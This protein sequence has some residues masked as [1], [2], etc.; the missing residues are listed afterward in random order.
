MAFIY[1]WSELN[2]MQRTELK[3]I[4]AFLL[5]GGIVGASF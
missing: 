4:G 2:H 3:I 5:V 1:Y